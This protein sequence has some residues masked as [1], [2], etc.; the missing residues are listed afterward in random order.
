[1]VGFYEIPRVSYFGNT[2]LLMKKRKNVLAILPLVTTWMD[3]KGITLSEMKLKREKNYTISLISKK[4]K[5]MRH[6]V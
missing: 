4:A 1:M 2:I 3:F 6:K 5:I